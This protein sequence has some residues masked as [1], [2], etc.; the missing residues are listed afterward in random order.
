MGETR[1]ACGI[2]MRKPLGKRPL[3]D[4]EGDVK[5]NL[6]EIGCEDGR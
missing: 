6:W 2:L 5:M 1:N 4:L 3:K